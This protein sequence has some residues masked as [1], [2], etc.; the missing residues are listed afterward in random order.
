MDNR[1]DGLVITF[2][3]ITA[4]KMLEATLRKQAGLG[5]VP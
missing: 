1:I 5:G 3:D 2:V 4:A